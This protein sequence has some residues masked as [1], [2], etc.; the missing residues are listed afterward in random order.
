VTPDLRNS[1]QRD[2][3]TACAVDEVQLTAVMGGWN[4]GKSTGGC[5]VQS[6]LSET[7]PGTTRLAITDTY[8]RADRVILP[9]LDAWLKPRGWTHTE[10]GRL[11][12]HPSNGS[13]IRVVNYMRASTRASSAN[14]LEGIN[15]ADAW[16]DE[17]QA[18]PAEALQKAQARVG[19][20]GGYPGVII[21]TGLP[22]AGAWW[23]ERAEKIAADGG[24]SR[25]LV[26]ASDVNLHN[27][28]DGWLDQQRR[29]LSPEEYDAMINAVPR[30]PTGQ[31]YDNFVARSWP[32]GNLLD[33]SPDDY[34]DH[35]ITLAVDFG[36]SP[37]ALLIA[38][39]RE[40]GLDV[41]VDELQPDDVD[42][43]A[44]AELI[45]ARWWRIAHAAGDPAG[46][47]RTDHDN[48]RSM[49]ELR[50]ALGIPHI[51]YTHEPERRAIPAGILTLRRLFCA[52]DG[53]R[54]MVV[55]RD[56]WD[57][58]RH[59][60]GRSIRRSILGYRYPESGGDVPKKDGVTDHAMDAA[61][62]FAINFR[63]FD[64]HVPAESYTPVEPSAKHVR[65]AASGWR[66]AQRGWRPRG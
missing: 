45:T 2:M 33:A 19:R 27:M 25:V 24:T 59:H 51:R 44:L 4:S 31:V 12:V 42:V 17:C 36:R 29:M 18:L 9:I 39:D 20:D 64:R 47:S 55:L 49:D 35:D 7:R 22:V 60:G 8:G 11:W 1:L 54:R 52:A 48:R 65:A 40:R 15:A 41:V 37:A 38:Q 10:S 16:M 56:V 23:V 43:Y 46:R 14:P 3:L 34:R 30:A 26:A 53:H 28:P 57:R 6:V 62:Y 5:F 21:C 66:P 32:D 58:G 50:I 61:R 63:W 13:R